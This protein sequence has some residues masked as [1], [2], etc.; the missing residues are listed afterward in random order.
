[1]RKNTRVIMSMDAIE[2]YG[3]EWRNVVLVITHRATQYMPAAEFF[4]RGQPEGYHPGYDE[5]IS[6]EPLF[7]LK[8]ADTGEELGFSLYKWE[9]R[10]AP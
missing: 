3:E 1:M 6:P 7:D 2:N 10:Y 4:R 5:G 9:L 8:R